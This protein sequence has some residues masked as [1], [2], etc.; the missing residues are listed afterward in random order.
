MRPGNRITS[1]ERRKKLK[2]ILEAR[3]FARIIEAHNGISAIVANDAR[4][5]TDGKTIEFDGIWE[6]SFTD[7]ASKGYPDAD[8]I[9]LE[10]RCGVI[11]QI[12]N[13]STKPVIFDGDTGGE[14]SNFE[15]MVQ[16]LEG[17]GVS[18]VI[19]EDKTFP[20]RNSLDGEA[21]QSQE[22]VD[23]FATKIKRGR[24]VLLTGDFMIIARVESLI[25]GSG[26]EDALKRTKKYLQAGADGIMIHSR[27]K[28]PDD[29]LEFAQRYE[30]LC[31]ELGFR[32]YLVC[33]PTSYNSIREEE[34]RDKGF[35]IVIYANQLLRASHKS[36]NEVAELILKN[37]RSLEVDP[38]S[39]SVSEIFEKVG[40]LEIRE[41]DKLYRKGKAQVIIPAAGED[42]E[43]GEIPKAMLEI[44]GKPL[45]QRQAE[46]LKKCGIK[47]IAVVRGYQKDKFSIDGITYV[48]NENYSKYGI[49]HSLFCAEEDMKDGF[50]YIN[51]DIL[52][53]GEIIKKLLEVDDDMVIV[54]DNSYEHHKHDIDKKLD[55][56]ITKEK[57]SDDIRVLGNIDNEVVGI[58][59]NID[60]ETA[61]YE[62]IGIIYFSEYGAKALKK[63]Y[64]ECKETHKGRFH[65]ASDFDHASDTDMIQ[66]LIDG[67][68]RVKIMEIHKG[69]ME[70]HSKED[71]ELAQ[72]KV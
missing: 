45:L 44:K 50:I 2:N 25:S 20:K 43:F 61:D 71:Y 57:P 40:F 51:S 64:H 38:L 29:V 31:K 66:E 15:H 37:G 16:R 22:D 48:D 52:F 42:K 26:M 70:I 27:D 35:N 6:S 1:E 23:V 28:K 39:S 5:E 17:L 24:D 11:E 9:G 59:K 63:I 3:G 67:G 46:A 69:W 68:F 58:G 19:I 33:V 13:A 12:L 30:E 18:A 56:V 60:K 47:D 36:M 14:A 65:E 62:Y 21:I 4:I 10:S 34:L 53:D 7:S 32:K 72:K 8:I 41:K 55:L 49:L 54:V